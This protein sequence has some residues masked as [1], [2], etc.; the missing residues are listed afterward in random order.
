MA[1]WGWGVILL[2]LL[3]A[4][5]LVAVADAITRVAVAIL[6]EGASPRR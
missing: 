1:R 5:V 3:A 6:P 2:R 4:R